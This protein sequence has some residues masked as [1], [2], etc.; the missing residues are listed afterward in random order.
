[1][2]MAEEELRWRVELRERVEL[3]GRVEL[4]LQNWGYS[5]VPGLQLWE[6]GG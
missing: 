3:R 5:E 6:E 1:M 2:Y 4:W